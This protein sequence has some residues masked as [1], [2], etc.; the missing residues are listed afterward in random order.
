MVMPIIAGLEMYQTHA[1]PNIRGISNAAI[2]QLLWENREKLQNQDKF[3]VVWGL[4][5]AFG[6]VS[7]L[8]SIVPDRIVIIKGNLMVYLRQF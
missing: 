6:S 7:E 1:D 3:S 4:H 8:P 5:F 2:S